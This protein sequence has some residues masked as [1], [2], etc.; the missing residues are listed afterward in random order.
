MSRQLCCFGIKGRNI[1]LSFD[2]QWVSPGGC[3][4]VFP[5]Q[6]QQNVPC[7]HFSICSALAHPLLNLSCFKN[8][9]WLR[10]TGIHWNPP[11]LPSPSPSPCPFFSQLCWSAHAQLRKKESI[12]GV[13]REK[14]EEEVEQGISLPHTILKSA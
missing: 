5:L 1:L 13:K 11:N 2:Y 6:R 9:L 4:N 8:L 14:E 7:H 10:M 3:E 12:T